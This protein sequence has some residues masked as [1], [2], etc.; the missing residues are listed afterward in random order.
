MQ[1]IYNVNIKGHVQVKSFARGQ[2]VKNRAG[3]TWLFSL[4]PT[5][6]PRHLKINMMGYLSYLFR[7]LTLSSDIII[8]TEYAE[9]TPE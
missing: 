4:F 5:I 1:A 7:A 8:P 2:Q 3:S 6:F 9:A